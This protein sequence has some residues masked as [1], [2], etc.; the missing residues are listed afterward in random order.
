MISK[1]GEK[2]R[3]K[4]FR[5]RAR[6]IR[7]A[8]AYNTGSSQSAGAE[9]G[10]MRFTGGFEDLE[11][12]VPCYGSLTDGREAF[13]RQSYPAMGRFKAIVR[14]PGPGFRY[15]EAV[16]S[17]EEVC[18][19]DSAPESLRGRSPK[20]FWIGRH[21]AVYTL[22]AGNMM[23]KAS[24]HDGD[25]GWVQ[26]DPSVVE[27]AV[28]RLQPTKVEDWEA[29]AFIARRRP[30][31]NPEAI[32]RDLIEYWSWT[33]EGIEGNMAT[34]WHMKVPEI[35]DAVRR[36][37]TPEALEERRLLLETRFN[38]GDVVTLR[39]GR[40]VLITVGD[41]G[42]K[43]THPKLG[44]MR[45]LFITDPLAPE[46]GWETVKVRD[47]AR[48]VSKG[49]M[50]VEEAREH[51][52]E[53][54]WENSHMEVKE[55]Y[56]QKQ[57]EELNRKRRERLE[58]VP[59]RRLLLRLLRELNTL[60]RPPAPEGEDE[61]PDDEEEGECSEAEETSVRIS[62]A[63]LLD[64]RAKRT[65]ALAELLES[66]R[67]DALELARRVAAMDATPVGGQAAEAE[68]EPRDTGLLL[69]VLAE[70]E[71]G[72]ELLAQPGRLH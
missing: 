8:L 16:V 47:V 52:G 44:T 6:W 56:E 28:A 20:G 36:R 59:G 26:V 24:V 3:A 58:K 31:Y 69:D 37:T 71:G 41:E 2:R 61:Y 62:A 54:M 63:E 60:R 34:D 65:V 32:A 33:P 48:V 43:G 66:G 64:T 21:G 70:F 17:A 49:E 72:R 7:R 23:G 68:L 29:F 19:V 38:A 4:P 45:L 10:A 27:Y 12:L 51:L 67:A 35:A 22:G 5:N 1:D 46:K 30:D 53:S 9:G 50:T 18:D 13:L 57:R 39:D 40:T 55:E 25:I 11:R 42:E 15:R 14:D